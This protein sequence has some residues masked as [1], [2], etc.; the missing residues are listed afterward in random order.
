MTPPTLT[1]GDLTLRPYEI[2]DFEAFAGIF[3]SPRSIYMDGPCDRARAWHYFTNDVA[4]WPLFGWGSLTVTR[5]GEVMGFTGLTR[6]PEYPEPEFGWLLTDAAEGQ[7]IATRAAR[8]L[9][10]W[11]WTA[12]PLKT[13]VSYIDHRN[14]ASIRVAEKLGAVRDDAAARPA[15]EP[16]VYRHLKD[17]HDG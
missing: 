2:A 5:G 7:G 16:L 13:F 4:A 11:V 10:D 17:R 9:T 1:A 12:T 8:A 3:A 14:A 15:D 6:P